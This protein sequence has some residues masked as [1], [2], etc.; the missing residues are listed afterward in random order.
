MLIRWVLIIKVLIFIII[1]IYIII[2]ICSIVECSLLVWKLMLV[3]LVREDDK[4]VFIFKIVVNI[5]IVCCFI[6]C[7]FSL[8]FF[9]VMVKCSRVFIVLVFEFF[10][11]VVV[12]CLKE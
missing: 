9:K 2:C 10:G 4:F 3:L 6:V 7:F 8:L 11:E 1:I 5:F 12:C